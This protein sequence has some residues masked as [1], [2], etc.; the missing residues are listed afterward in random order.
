MRHAA[1]LT[2][3]MCVSV[4]MCL[5]IGTAMA[6]GKTSGHA[7]GKAAGHGR[8]KAH[9]AAGTGWQLVIN[10][11]SG[12]CMGVLSGSK[13]NGA[14]VVQWPCNGHRDQIWDIETCCLGSSWTFQNVNSGLCLNV[15]GGGSENGANMIQY[16]CIYGV[17]NERFG[18]FGTTGNYYTIQPESHI[19]S[20]V[21]VRSQS[22]AQGAQ[23]DQWGCNRG[24]NQEWLNS[25]A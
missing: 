18:L 14:R 7:G 4:A 17:A 21:E 23:I 13:A 5:A 16:T 9:A 8:A 3:T 1:K 20:C 22:R 12:F 2:L 19:S 11:N 25:A 15:A 10:R 6:G 24:A